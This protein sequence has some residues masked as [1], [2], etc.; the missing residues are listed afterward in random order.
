MPPSF[1]VP[2]DYCL[3]SPFTFGIERS[4]SEMERC[5]VFAA[6]EVDSCSN[7]EKQDEAYSEEV[8]A[9]DALADVFKRPFTG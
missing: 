6:P 2:L 4:M 5:F 3:F 1:F 8:S 9:R 7:H